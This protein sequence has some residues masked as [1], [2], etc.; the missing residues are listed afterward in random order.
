MKTTLSIL[1]LLVSLPALA[2]EVKTRT[3]MEPD[4]AVALDESIWENWEAPDPKVGEITDIA[5]ASRDI[6][7]I[8]TATRKVRVEQRREGLRY[9]VFTREGKRLYE[10]LPLDELRAWE[11]RLADLLETSRASYWAGE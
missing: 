2:D 4:P 11:P 10:A 5:P 9:T 7:T 6:V 1:L 8:L 3:I